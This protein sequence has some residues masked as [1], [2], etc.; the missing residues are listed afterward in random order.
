MERS[1]NPPNGPQAVTT[2]RRK[3][4]RR[5]R[6]ATK[7]YPIRKAIP[8][9]F[10]RTGDSEA[11]AEGY[12]VIRADILD[13]VVHDLCHRVRLLEGWRNLGCNEPIEKKVPCS[14]TELRVIRRQG[15]A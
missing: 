13:R 3:Y 2:K 8:D 7:I 11:V 4:E 6:L 9:H 5:S 14:E 12:G 10:D 15:A 1:V